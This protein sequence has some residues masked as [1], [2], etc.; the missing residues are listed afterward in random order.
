M[1]RNAKRSAVRKY[2]DRVAGRYDDSYADAFWQWHDA[3][4]WDYLRPHLPRDMSGE[5]VDL[6]C[7]TGKWAAKLV[8]SGYRVTC[9]DISPK[10]LDQARAKIDAQGASARSSFVQADISEL[11][12][13]DADRF[14]LAVAFGDAIGCT[15]SPRRTM[16]A[17]RRVLREDGILVATFDNKLAAIDHYLER[18]DPRELSRFLRDGKTHWLTHNVEERFPIVTFRPDEVIALA[19]NAE[20]EVLETIGKTVLPMRHYRH[21]LETADSRR[22]WAKIEKMVC[23]NRFALARASHIQIACRAAP[24]R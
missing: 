24:R 4:T 20:F 8:K 10:M 6:G 17:I 2:H 13:F 11:A 5:I 9:V 15:P 21:L 12:D 19:E 18:G 14:S 7:G 16:R 1:T 3:L 22:I 23:R